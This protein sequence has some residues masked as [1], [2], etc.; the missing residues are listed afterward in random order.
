M[1]GQ[2]AR[3]SRVL[4]GSSSV[5]VFVKRARAEETVISQWPQQ[6]CTKYGAKQNDNDSAK[7][8]WEILCCKILF[9]PKLK[10]QESFST[11]GWLAFKAGDTP[12]FLMW[13]PCMLQMPHLIL[14]FAWL[15]SALMTTP[16]Q[17]LR[18]QMTQL[19][20]CGPFLRS[21]WKLLCYFCG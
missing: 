1:L 18:H 14:Y 4:L 12:L 10:I 17:T 2:P 11:V 16:L 19:A 8:C 21:V 9:S 3:S 5:L 15:Y 13:L 7:V 20:S 6:R